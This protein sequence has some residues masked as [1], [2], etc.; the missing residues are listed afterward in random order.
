MTRSEF[1]KELNGYMNDDASEYYRTIQAISLLNREHDLASIVFPDLNLN[2]TTKLEKNLIESID[3]TIQPE[4]TL[5]FVQS[6]R[7]LKRILL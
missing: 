2:L 5:A 4:K 1:L 6:Q 3:R 7:L